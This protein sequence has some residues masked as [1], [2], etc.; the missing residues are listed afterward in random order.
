MEWDFLTGSGKRVRLETS[1]KLVNHDG[2]EVEVEGIARDV[3]ERHR[4][5]KEILDVSTREQRRIGHDLHDGVCQQLAGI[6]VL[7]DILADKLAEHFRPEAGDAQ[8][9]THLVKQANHQTR[10]VARGLFPV[11]LEENGLVSALEELAQNA[12]AYYHTR[13]EFA[14]NSPVSVRDHSAAQHLYFI[15]QEA[16]LNAAKHGNAGLIQVRIE[17]AAGQG[18]I[19]TVRDNGKGLPQPSMPGPGMGVR[20]MKYRARMIGATIA[21]ES[22]P[23]EGTV[24]ICQLVREA[25]PS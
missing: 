20:I 2:Q 19:L 4:L 8:K 24:V 7:A 25:K 23:G 13:C 1:T 10:G 6:A 14:C 16:V 5:E 21:V 3:T 11:R 22:S 18:C 15:A 9:I 12:G 17:P